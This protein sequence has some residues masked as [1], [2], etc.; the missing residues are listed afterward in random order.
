MSHFTVIVVGS[1]VEE[2][3]EPYAE[4]DFEEK[5]AKFEDIEDNP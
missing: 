1:N 4:Q 2:Q 3:M 5:Y